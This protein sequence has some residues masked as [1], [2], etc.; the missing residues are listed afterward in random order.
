MSRNWITV[1]ALATSLLPATRLSG[2]EHAHETTTGRPRQA[3]ST[4]AVPLSGLLAASDTVDPAVTERVARAMAPELGWD[5]AR[6]A[7]EI[8][9]YAQEAAAEGLVAADVAAAAT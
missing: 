7:A 4:E 1:V 3:E 9:A 6:I 2:Q 5:E 8:Q